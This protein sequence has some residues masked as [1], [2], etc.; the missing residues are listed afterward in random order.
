MNR[1]GHQA[2]AQAAWLG[3]AAV[4]PL[5]W[6]QVVA[7]AV[8]ASSMCADD[9]S[10]DVDQGGW[11][12]NVLPGGHRWVTHM[13]E[14]VAALAWAVI[15]FSTTAG[16]GWFGWAAAAA[17]GSHLAVDC[18]FGRIPLLILGGRRVGLTFDTGGFTE[19]VLTWAFTVAA[20]PLA[21]IAVG[22]S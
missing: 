13:P 6:Q 2:A 21:W 1:L 16:F 15:Y 8:V 19:R 5:P 20:L 18:L 10:P 4:H 11:L 9:W 22:A 7:G 14:L 3:F 17:W 12:A